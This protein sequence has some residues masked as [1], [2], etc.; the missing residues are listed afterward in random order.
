MCLLTFKL[1][2]EVAR[3]EGDHVDTPNSK[4]SSNVAE[5]SFVLVRMFRFDVKTG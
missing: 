1:V 2:S 3:C 5:G 4:D